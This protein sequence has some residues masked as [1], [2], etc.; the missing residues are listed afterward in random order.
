MKNILMY[1]ATLFAFVLMSF[2]SAQAQNKK[3]NL[4]AIEFDKKIKALPKAIILDVRTASEFSEGH[5]KNAKNIDW[6]GSNFDKETSKLNKSK[7]ILV[8]CLAGGRSA[9]AASK[10]REAGFK[11]VYELNGGMK[12]WRAAKLPEVK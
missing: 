6:N 3:T 1:S 12:E 4:T 8:Y 11:Q 9:A 5:I 7:P 2:N 10:L